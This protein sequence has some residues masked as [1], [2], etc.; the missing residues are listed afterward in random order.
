[1][2]VYHGPRENGAR[3]SIDVLFRSAAVHHGTRVVGVL[4]SGSLH[5]GA[6]GLSAVGRC[7]GVTVVQAPYDAIDAEMPRSALEATPVNHSVPTVELP[8]LLLDIIGRA[9]PE[10]A[11]VP[12]DLRVEARVAL[13]AADPQH[14]AE[15]IGQP[16]PLSCPGCGGPLSDHLPTTGATSGTLT[17]PTRCWLNTPRPWSAPSGSH[18][19]P[20]RSEASFSASCSKTLAGTGQRALGGTRSTC[21]RSRPKQ[22]SSTKPS[23]RWFRRPCPKT[24][25][26]TAFDAAADCHATRGELAE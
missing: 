26:A 8:A 15:M 2:R 6:L 22:R 18:F 21:V 10:S 17:A 4:L 24:R 20:S 19:V 5:D 1:M 9:V 23:P 3:P 13:A 16:V 7:G 12:D 25:T 11:P 14:P